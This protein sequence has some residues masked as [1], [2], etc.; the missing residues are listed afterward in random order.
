MAVVVPASYVG[1]EIAVPV[2]R[3]DSRAL[4]IACVAEKGRFLL[5][6]IIV[7][8]KTLKVELYELWFPLD[9]CC[10]IHQKMIL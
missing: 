10:I 1:T 6:Y 8:R 9:S 4:V 7:T 5:P 2:A 3:S